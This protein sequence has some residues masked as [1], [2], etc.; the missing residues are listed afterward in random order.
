M[1]SEY[2][3][4]L[5]IPEN[6]KHI[7]IDVGLGQFN[8]NSTNWLKTEKDLLVIMFDPNADSINHSLNIMVTNNVGKPNNNMYYII[9]VALSNTES[10]TK[11]DFYKMSADAGTSSLYNPIDPTLGPIKE[12]TTVDTYSLKHFFDVFPWDRFEYIE[13][14][15]IDAQGS[16]F[17]I[18]KGAGSYLMDR[19]MYI[20]AEPEDGQYENCAHNTSE[21]MEQYLLSLNFIKIDHPNTRDP[22]FLNKKFLH[23]QDS[24]YIFQI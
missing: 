9:P 4:R 1:M 3:N 18:I 11:M 24:T 14:I 22:T 8:I 13:Y 16:D 17:D 7:K 6:I 21:N 12:K 19:V 20:T 15:K 5:I 10:P 2:L 23:L